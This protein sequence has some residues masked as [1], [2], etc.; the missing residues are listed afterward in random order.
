MILHDCCPVVPVIF[1]Q[2]DSKYTLAMRTVLHTGIGIHLEIDPALTVM[3]FSLSVSDFGL[4]QLLKPDNF[5]L[6][7]TF[8]PIN[9]FEYYTIRIF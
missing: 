2:T 9:S 8:I 1:F 7:S 4:K 3:T 5:Y 6:I